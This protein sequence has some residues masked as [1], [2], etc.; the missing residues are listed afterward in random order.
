MKKIL[1]ISIGVLSIG[2]GV[3]MTIGFVFLRVDGESIDPLWVDVLYTL[4][5]GVAPV[6]IGVFFLRW[7]PVT[8]EGTNS[9]SQ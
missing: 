2:L 7:Q 8:E 5:F 3:F 4:V 9:R 1:A 6:A